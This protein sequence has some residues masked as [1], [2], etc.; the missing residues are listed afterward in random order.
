MINLRDLKTELRDDPLGLGYAPLVDTAE[1]DRR[2]AD[3][4]NAVEIN[5][6]VKTIT[7]GQLWELL[8]YAD[9]EFIL[10][11]KPE[12]FRIMMS[13][14]AID[15]RNSSVAQALFD[16]LLPPISSDFSARLTQWRRV[17][18]SRAQQLF[19]EDVEPGDIARARRS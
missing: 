4:M 19:D 12:L 14:P 10:T 15:L 7:P 17:K 3:L 9:V 18:I 13:L 8:G 6:R 2:V 16:E 1:S 5:E 11:A